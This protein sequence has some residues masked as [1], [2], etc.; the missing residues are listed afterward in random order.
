MGLV[1]SQAW[2]DLPYSAVTHSSWQCQCCYS[3]S[4]CRVLIISYTHFRTTV[5][6]QQ[7]HLNQHASSGNPSIALLKTSNIALKQSLICSSMGW[8]RTPKIVVNILP[9]STEANVGSNS[10][11]EGKNRAEKQAHC[12]FSSRL[13]FFWHPVWGR[14]GLVRRCGLISIRSCGTAGARSG[15]RGGRLS[16]TRSA[17]VPSL[18][19]PRPASIK[20][21]PAES[22]TW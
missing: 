22:S 14:L 11:F 15:T 19:L 9:S 2:C 8:K 3:P 4:C 13:C 6:S 21:A 16:E 1:W 5:C 17:L 18:G 20:A 7:R 10:G 12:S